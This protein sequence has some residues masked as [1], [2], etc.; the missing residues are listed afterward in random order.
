MWSVLEGGHY[1]AYH[2]YLSSNPN[3]NSEV[4]GI[5]IPILQIGNLKQTEVVVQS[6]T[7]SM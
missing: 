1:S 7:F 6:H 3:N 5:T 4:G 2:K